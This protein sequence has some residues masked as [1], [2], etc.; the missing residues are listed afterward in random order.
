MR[1]SPTGSRGAFRA[2]FT[3]FEMAAVLLLLG[4]LAA[5]GLPAF[6]RGPDGLAWRMACDQLQRDLKTARA[7]AVAHRRPTV[8]QFA[9]KGY[10]V[11]LGRGEPL[12]RQLPAGITVAVYRDGVEVETLFFDP[13]GHSG[14]AVVELAAGEKEALFQLEEDGRIVRE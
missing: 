9:A 2:G 4:L 6:F 7:T 12:R 5:I 1:I 13:H 14:A 8:V 3:L 11:S 10:T